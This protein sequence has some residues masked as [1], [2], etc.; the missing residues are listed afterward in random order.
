MIYEEDQLPE[1]VQDEFAPERFQGFGSAADLFKKVVPAGT[2]QK[3]GVAPAAPASGGYAPSGVSA[4]QMNAVLSRLD[5]I[6]R[7]LQNVSQQASQAYALAARVDASARKA[8]EAAENA[9]HIASQPVPADPRVDALA[10]KFND[11]VQKVAGDIGDIQGAVGQLRAAVSSGG[12][13]A[14]PAA[15][16]Y[17]PAPQ[18]VPQ[19]DPDAAND[20][21]GPSINAR[22]IEDAQYVEAEQYVPP[23]AQ[24]ADT[25]ASDDQPQADYQGYDGDDQDV[26]FGF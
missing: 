22:D 8:A 2:L 5:R 11:L 13:Y 10:Q 19:Y 23:Q 3:L 18:Y 6:E 24:P 26:D 4:S 15:P 7:Q 17:Q 21:S 9:A 16:V 20:S 25:S 12:G 1:E 14:P